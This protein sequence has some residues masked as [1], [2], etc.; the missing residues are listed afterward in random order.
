MLRSIRQ[1]KKTALKELTFMKFYAVGAL[2]PVFF[3][4]IITNLVTHTAKTT[5][6]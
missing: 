4:Y 2:L 5:Y 3:I 6:E 1:Q